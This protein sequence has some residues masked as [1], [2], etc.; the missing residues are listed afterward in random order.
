MS[1]NRLALATA[2]LLGGCASADARLIAA[3][4]AV[5]SVPAAV[6][7]P[8]VG[9]G[10]DAADDPA[11]WINSANPA[12]SRVLGTDKQ[13]GLYVYDLAGSISQFLPAG[14]L[15]NVDVRQGLAT[16]LGVADVAI[17][18]NRTD[19]SISIFHIDRATGVLTPSSSIP[20]DQVEP[21]GI[22]AGDGRAQGGDGAMAI[23]TY[24]TGAITIYRFG[25]TSG[26]AP[27]VTATIK[28]SSQ[29]EGC[30]FDEV[31]NALF[32]GEEDVGLWRIDFTGT[33]PG[34]PRLIDRVG[35]G[36][37]LVADVEGVGLWAGPDGSGYI[38]LSS[39]T[40]NRYM[41]YNRTS[42]NQLVGS[43]AI[44]PGAN[45]AIDGVTHTDGLEV[46][47]V[48]LGPQFPRGGL[49]VQDD[50]NDAPG[51][52][53]PLAQNFKFVDWRTIEAIISPSQPN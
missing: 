13:A 7:T 9:T 10:D 32:V 36:T 33:T 25:E 17:A 46:T 30:V 43:F 51:R 27:R 2:L 3:L 41:V 18:S 22:C 4:P 40:A 24:K 31:Q 48:P 37:G 26:A 19:N 45:G 5:Q 28:L 29:L 1:R 38:V 6:E 15:N 11:I 21:Y 20:A 44:G 35:S 23:V 14:R 8:P 47:S 42:P 52:L 39:Q 34:E 12:A 53:R 50:R 49:F 16:N